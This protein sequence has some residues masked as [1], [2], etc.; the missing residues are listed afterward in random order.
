[1]PPAG[2]AESHHQHILI[3]IFQTHKNGLRYDMVMV[4]T[5]PPTKNSQKPVIYLWM[6]D[7]DG[8]CLA[9][10]VFYGDLQAY[11]QNREEVPASIASTKLTG[12]LGR[13][14]VHKEHHQKEASEGT[15]EDIQEL[16]GPSQ[17]GHQIGRFQA[18]QRFIGH[19]ACQ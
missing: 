5:V 6:M 15:E 8:L 11:G 13:H 12:D 2:E 4:A 7:F 10:G 18:K 19:P 1:M 9:A 16:P 17:N 3:Y 14:E